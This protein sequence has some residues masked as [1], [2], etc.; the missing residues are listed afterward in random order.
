MVADPAVHRY[1]Q[2]CITE[3]NGRLNRWETIKKFRILDHDLAGKDGDLTPSLKVKRKSLEA[4]FESLLD[5]MYDGRSPQL[6]ERSGTPRRCRS[7]S[8]T[9]PIATTALPVPTP[10]GVENRPVREKVSPSLRAASMPGVPC[11]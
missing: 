10:T 11:P 2:G 6:I 7:S 5:S 8:Q 9:A 1:L 4:K 3:L